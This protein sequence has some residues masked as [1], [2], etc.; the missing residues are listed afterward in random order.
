M[1]QS[2]FLRREERLTASRSAAARV[3]RCWLRYVHASSSSRL[4]LGL[5]VLSS[6]FVAAPLSLLGSVA[7]ILSVFLSIDELRNGVISG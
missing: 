1:C 7:V 2:I 6:T 4:S 3:P 5:T